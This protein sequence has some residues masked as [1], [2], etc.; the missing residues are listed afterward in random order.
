[1]P[2]YLAYQFDSIQLTKERLLKILD[3][4]FDLQL[5]NIDNAEEWF[6][7]TEKEIERRKNFRN[8]EVRLRMERAEQDM[9]YREDYFNYH[10]LLRN[11]PLLE[12]KFV[13]VSSEAS[14]YCPVGFSGLNIWAG[15]SGSEGSVKL[16]GF[17][18]EMGAYLEVVGIN[19][20][21][22]SNV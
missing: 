8:P 19:Y 13:H 2:K 18:S 10:S 3:D 22:R 6:E 1:M 20:V 5:R 21:D 12:I 14:T 16:I 11:N 15:H 7:W 4:Y 9:L 17:K